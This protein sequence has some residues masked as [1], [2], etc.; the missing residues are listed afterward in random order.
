MQPDGIPDFPRLHIDIRKKAS[1]KKGIEKLI[2]VAVEQSK[3]ET[4]YKNRRSLSVFHHPVADQLP[5]QI[6]FKCRRQKNNIHRRNPEIH[7]IQHSQQRIDHFLTF[8][9]SYPKRDSK[10]NHISQYQYPVRHHKCKNKLP[11]LHP[12][13]LYVPFFT[14]RLYDPKSDGIA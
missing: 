2:K 6:F 13:L 9:Q 4:R 14:S 11:W 7:V 5:K 12:V 3:H 10:S 8:Q 1:D